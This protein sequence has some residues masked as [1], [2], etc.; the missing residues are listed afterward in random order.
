[1]DTRT[2]SSF[3]LFLLLL[4]ASF[5]VVPAGAM[6]F[7]GPIAAPQNTADTGPEVSPVLF[8]RGDARLPSGVLHLPACPPVPARVSAGPG[9]T[10]GPAAIRPGR[11]ETLVL[12]SGGC[13]TLPVLLVIRP[14]APS[15][16]TLISPAGSAVSLTEDDLVT[17]VNDAVVLS[18]RAGKAAAIRE[19]ADRNGSFTRGDLYIWAYD[20]NGTN[21]AHP[22]HPEFRG[23]N[24]LDLADPS[25]FRMIEA[26]RDVA[27]D[28]SGFVQYAYENPVTGKTE[29]KLAYVKRV[30][31]DWWIA[32]GIYGENLSLSQTSPAVVRH[33]LEKKVAGAV[34]FARINGRGTA[35]SLFND[36]SGQFAA[37]GN[38][39]FA[40]AMNGTT[41]AM[42]FE[43]ARIG[44]NERDLKDRN[45]VAIGERK[46]QL[47]GEGGGFFY[48]VF[49]DPK[50]Q[51]PAF[52]V[53]FVRAVDAEW[54]VGAGA[55]LPDVPADFS[56][57]AR[58]RMV[59]HVGSALTFM[60]THGKD[61]ALRTFN[62]PDGAFS[63]KDMYIFVFDPDGTYLASPYLPGIVG[64][65]RLTSRDPY[66]EYHVQ[67]ILDTAQAG[68]GFTYYFLEDPANDFRVS[69]KLAYVKTADNGL[70]VGTGTSA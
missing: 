33:N 22:Y 62:D 57:D 25:G 9:A 6:N 56:P 54:A 10:G 55:Y 15:G 43:P 37:D 11:S 50:T 45:G 23:Q 3:L 5:C 40:F 27:R 63:K 46:I 60:K 24:K 51:Q 8:A 13:R 16:D 64:S 31:A 20:F 28:G 12:P 67:A 42:P 18:H 1:M 48:Y 38:Y 44:K 70:I 26:M 14:G 47:A 59:S 36:P 41:L 32:S 35:L 58:D 7:I 39:I 17:F 19:F 4:T 66:G 49:T 52:K 61:E 30:D 34:D 69:L 2:G 68:G 65:N 21:L 53:S 29:P